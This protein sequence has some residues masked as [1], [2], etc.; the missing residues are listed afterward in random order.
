[1]AV[2]FLCSFFPFFP[3]LFW[4]DES[5]WVPRQVGSSLRSLFS[6]LGYGVGKQAGPSRYKGKPSLVNQARA[7]LDRDACTVTSAGEMLQTCRSY[8]RG[9]LVCEEAG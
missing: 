4:K 2:C 6:A 3:F 8:A 5:G 9:A 1:M 7:F